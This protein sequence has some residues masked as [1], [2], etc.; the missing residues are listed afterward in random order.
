MY[1]YVLAPSG[2]RVWVCD[3]HFVS[4]NATCFGRLGSRKLTT[5]IPSLPSETLA[6]VEARRLRVVAD[7]AP[8]VV[9]TGRVDRDEGK[10]AYYRDVALVSGAIVEPDLF[11]V[12][13]PG[14]DDLVKR[15][16][17]VGPGVH[18]ATLEREVRSLG[19]QVLVDHDGFARQH[20]DVLG[21]VVVV[22][23]GAGG[24]ASEKSG[25]DSQQPN[26]GFDPKSQI[27]TPHGMIGQGPMGVVVRKKPISCY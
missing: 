11:D 10:D 17:L 22:V 26:C 15:S 21:V 24:H 6:L 14:A 3:P 4:T 25:D 19:V 1:M 20:L 9:G 5:R 7:R 12:A 2:T 13:L 16:S 18:P 27:S 8:T 23:A